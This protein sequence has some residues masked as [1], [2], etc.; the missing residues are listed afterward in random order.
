MASIQFVIEQIKQNP[1]RAVEHLPIREVCLELG[2][3]WRERCL[4]PATTLALFMRQIMDGNSSCAQVRHGSD[5]L[6][7][8]QAYC[9]ARKRLSLAVIQTLSR[10]LCD[11]VRATRQ[12]LGCARKRR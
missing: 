9:K 4:D 6:F 2:V 12:C 1:S 7:S 3:D 10:R 11:A 5:K 8:P